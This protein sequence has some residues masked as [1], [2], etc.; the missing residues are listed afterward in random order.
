MVPCTRQA[1]IEA[2]GYPSSLSEACRGHRWAQR[3]ARLPVAHI[4]IS[5]ISMRP[6]KPTHHA[7]AGECVPAE[8]DA[9]TI[10]DLAPLVLESFEVGHIWGGCVIERDNGGTEGARYIG[11]AVW[12]AGFASQLS[13]G[14]PSGGIKM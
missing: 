10:L 6:E 14:R 12:N 1:R 13:M 11:G 5:S 8:T 2:V 7:R 3:G 4:S 9:I